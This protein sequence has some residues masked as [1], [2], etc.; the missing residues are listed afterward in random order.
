MI[1]S[2]RY[3]PW[4]VTRYRPPLCI[5]S[6]APELSTRHQP[7]TDTHCCTRWGRLQLICMCRYVDVL[8]VD[9]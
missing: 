2:T 1:R 6:L 9:M 7:S 5:S 8:C 3:L 4:L